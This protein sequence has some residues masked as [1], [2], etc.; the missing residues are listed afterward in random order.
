MFPKSIYQGAESIYNIKALL[1]LKEPP[2]SKIHKQYL[3][4]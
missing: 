3:K 4:Q 1:F 2:Y